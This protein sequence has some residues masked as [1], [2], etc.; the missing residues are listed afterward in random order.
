[1]TV[2]FLLENKL[3]CEKRIFLLNKKRCDVVAL[4]SCQRDVTH[5]MVE[6]RLRS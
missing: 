2:N 5:Q 6:Q 4:R 1:M 3:I